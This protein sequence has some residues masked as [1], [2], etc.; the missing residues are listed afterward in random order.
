MLGFRFGKWYNT[1]KSEIFT[2]RVLFLKHFRS[3][4]VSAL[5]CR[6]VWLERGSEPV[7]TEG[8]PDDPETTIRR[9]ADLRKQIEVRH[10]QTDETKDESGLRKMEQE[11]DASKAKLQELL[12]REQVRERL[13]TSPDL[14]RLIML[15]E[16]MPGALKGLF[17]KEQGTAQ[18]G[19]GKQFLID[20]PENSLADAALGLGMIDFRENGE[21]P[22]PQFVMVKKPMA[23]CSSGS[24]VSASL[25]VAAEKPPR[26]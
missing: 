18:F 17:C 25:T 16:I 12:G 19:I 21:G 10:A 24:A 7:S 22:Q 4:W 2:A 3:E 9:L 23:P 1:M 6:L 14:S 15:D 26:G 8:A 13:R 5:P 20:M 11:F